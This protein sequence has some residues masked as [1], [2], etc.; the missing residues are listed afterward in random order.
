MWAPP[1]YRPFYDVE[2]LFT[3]FSIY[4]FMRR[5]LLKGPP[6]IEGGDSFTVDE[7]METHN[8]SQL[9]V[10]WMTET[11]LVVQPR[12]VYLCSPSGNLVRASGAIFEAFI[13]LHRSHWTWPLE[14]TSELNILLDHL[15]RFPNSAFFDHIFWSID[16]TTMSIA[17]DV[18]SP[19]DF[20]RRAKESNPLRDRHIRIARNFEGWSICVKEADVAFILEYFDLPDEDLIETTVEALS[21]K[22]PDLESR[23]Q[24]RPGL[25]PLVSAAYERAFPNGHGSLTL[26][27]AAREVEFE[28]G[29]SF[30]I[31]TLKRALGKKA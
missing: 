4:D 21:P 9:H 10:A 29:R 31:D 16:T 3:R 8:M 14:E 23:K 17:V 12:P 15:R 18:E 20:W 25:V 1:G 2:A 27:Q 7:T 13:P 24:G 28:L 19:I 6:S 5:I 11:A 30:H 26:K 22:S